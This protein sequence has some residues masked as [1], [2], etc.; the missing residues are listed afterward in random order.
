MVAPTFHPM[1]NAEDRKLQ[2]YFTLSISGLAPNIILI[3]KKRLSTDSFVSDDPRVYEPVYYEKL[4]AKEY[5]ASQ[6]RECRLTC[7]F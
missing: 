1:R 6:K 4:V 2:S 7:I 3:E 5:Y